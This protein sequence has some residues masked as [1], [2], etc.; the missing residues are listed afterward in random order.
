[1]SDR[2]QKMEEAIVEVSARVGDCI[3]TNR[4]TVSTLNAHSDILSG[5]NKEIQSL[6]KE[7]LRLNKRLDNLE[8]A[9]K[10]ARDRIIQV[11]KTVNMNS[12][13]LK[14][15]NIVIE[16]MLETAN[17]D[18]RALACDIFSVIESKC[19]QEDIISAYRIGHSTDKSTFPR[20]VVVKLIDPLTKLILIEN[21]W[22]LIN[23]PTYGKIYL[24]DD[25][26]PAI[27]KERRTLREIAKFAHQQGYKGCK[28]SGSK[29][30]IE[31]RAYRYDTLHLLPRA[32]QLCNVKTRLV[33][34]GLGFQ[35]EASFL[36]NFYPATFRMEENVF[37]C[38]EQAY[39][40]F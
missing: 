8:A 37:S 25:L 26:P 27:K 29:L 14:N 36:S 19:S 18:C 23:H 34:D 30:V 13:M 21:K 35:G 7:N 9:G 1:M 32:L 22:K 4:E 16:G 6:K 10:A 3:T 20:P 28:A 11:E 31:G 2:T 12:H 33:G 15:S 5:A 39:Q 24:N 38:A 17:E 40:F